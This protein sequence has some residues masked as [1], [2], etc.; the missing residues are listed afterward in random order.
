M[1]ANSDSVL[2]SWSTD[3]CLCEPYTLT[4]LSNPFK[5]FQCK[6]NGKC[7]TAKKCTPWIQWEKQ[8]YLRQGYSAVWETMMRCDLALQPG[9]WPWTHVHIEALD[10]RMRWMYTETD[11]QTERWMRI[12]WWNNMLCGISYFFLLLIVLQ[13][14]SIPSCKETEGI[15]V[16]APGSNVINHTDAANSSAL[17]I[18]P[19]RPPTLLLSKPVSASPGPVL[20]A[21]WDP[22][23]LQM[24]VR[25][26]RG[27]ACWHKSGPGPLSTSPHL[28]VLPV[29]GGCKQTKQVTVIVTL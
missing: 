7:S 10:G 15:L 27:P 22:Q 2:Q 13:T 18:R 6:F 9:P 24:I 25:H 8:S 23:Q 28:T 12:E 5:T 19:W 4:S 21:S 11:T 1:G 16:N 17:I 14:H 20:Y 26:W 29:P 3:I